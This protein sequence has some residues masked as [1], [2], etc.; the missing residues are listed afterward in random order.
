MEGKGVG[1]GSLHE[2]P[3]DLVCAQ[4]KALQT[5]HEFVVE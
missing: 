2:I 1:L 5:R 4:D 3:L